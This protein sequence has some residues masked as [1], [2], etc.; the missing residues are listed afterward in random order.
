MP[1][2]PYEYRGLTHHFDEAARS[3]KVTAARAKL[4]PPVRALNNL[5]TQAVV[6]ARK[7]DV[8]SL[9]AS[10]RSLDHAE[11]EVVTLEIAL[12][13]ARATLDDARKLLKSLGGAK[14]AKDTKKGDEETPYD[15]NEAE[16]FKR[17]P[18]A[19]EVSGESYPDPSQSNIGA[20]RAGKEAPADVE[21]DN[22]ETAE[23]QGEQAAAE[24]KAAAKA[25]RKKSE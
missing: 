17:D 15:D 14:M 8:A 19:P 18:A 5:V 25:A 7:K 20:I 13:A 24:K 6:H 2:K 11:A 21:A 22:A 9:K 23:V 3:R 16:N 10:G 1:S 4:L 12:E